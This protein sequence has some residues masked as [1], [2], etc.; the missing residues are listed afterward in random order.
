MMPSMMETTKT[1]PSRTKPRRAA[2]ILRIT[3][4][5]AA[6]SAGLV[7]C[8][9]NNSDD[10]APTNDAA[11][12][13]DASDA[14]TGSAANT[15]NDINVTDIP[16]VEISQKTR[17]LYQDNCALCHGVAG[18]GDGSM[19]GSLP[20]QPRSFTSD[21]FKFVNDDMSRNEIIDTFVTLI[22]DGISDAMMPPYKDTITTEQAVNLSKFILELRRRATQPDD[23]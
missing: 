22:H 8:G 15:G 23:V 17:D 20:V 12:P 3:T 1:T 18:K 16:P 2:R 11:S 7:A 10:D 6:C 5:A 4:I 13:D 19:A 9:G 14:A 21:D